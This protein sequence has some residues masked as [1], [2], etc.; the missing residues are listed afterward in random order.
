MSLSAGTILALYW[1]YIGSV[2]ETRL[3]PVSKIAEMFVFTW[4]DLK[5]VRIKVGNGLGVKNRVQHRVW[6]AGEGTEPR[7]DI[8][9]THDESRLE[10]AL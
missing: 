4:N 9:A 6:L 3:S 5:W 10:W 1:H 8:P 2:V 7:R